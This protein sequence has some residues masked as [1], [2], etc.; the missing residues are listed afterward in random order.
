MTSPST[1]GTERNVARGTAGETRTHN[2][3]FMVLDTRFE[4]IFQTI[5]YH[6]KI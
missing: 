6:Y 2:L 5:L 4:L 3:R 1:K